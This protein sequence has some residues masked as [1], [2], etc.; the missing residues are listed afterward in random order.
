MH[1]TC[2]SSEASQRKGTYSPPPPSP[3]LM[4]CCTPS[5]LT[6]QLLLLVAAGAAEH[7]GSEQPTIDYVKVA[8]AY[9]KALDAGTGW[10]GIVKA[11]TAD[12]TSPWHGEVCM[13]HAVNVSTIKAYA[14]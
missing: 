4:K 1:H 2:T 6:A 13:L 12:A 10:T 14:E 5:M 9:G 8:T 7:L 3:L 11:T